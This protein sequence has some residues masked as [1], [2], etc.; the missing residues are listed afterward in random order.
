MQS[1]NV[2]AI[3]G[4]P[5]TGSVSEGLEAFLAKLESGAGIED[6][7]AKLAALREEAAKARKEAA[8]KKTPEAGGE[9]AG[10]G[11]V[12]GSAVAAAPHGVALTATYSAAAARIAGY[13]PGGGP[14][15]KMV[16]GIVAIERNT[17][18]MTI[19]Q[20]QFLAGW[21]VA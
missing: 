7:A 4:E 2:A 21:R 3:G 20:Q 5:G 13:Q 10:G 6:A 18:E 19:Q 8:K 9:G 16:D 12:P 15:K 17:K 14:E 11:G 1:L